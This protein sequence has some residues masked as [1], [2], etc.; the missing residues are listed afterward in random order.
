MWVLLVGAVF[1]LLVAT[2]GG[3][4]VWVVT[5]EEPE[6]LPAPLRV[7]AA[8]ALVLV[9]AGLAAVHLVAA[10]GLGART[11]RGWTTAVILGAL[12]TAGGCLGGVVLLVV[13]LRADARRACGVS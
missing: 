5:G 7:A 1:H 13:L 8:G 10:R 9:T 2:V 6:P 12:Y 3:A 11:R 4:A